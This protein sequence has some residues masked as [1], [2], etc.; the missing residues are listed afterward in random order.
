MEV[1]NFRKE[2]A[3]RR[4]RAS[5][6]TGN[7]ST[8]TGSSYGEKSCFDRRAAGTSFTGSVSH[9]SLLQEQFGPKEEFAK[10]ENTSS[11]RS[12]QGY[13]HT[14]VRKVGRCLERGRFLSCLARGKTNQP[15]SQKDDF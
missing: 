10:Q 6:G 11:K 2:G 7:K 13:R 3:V 1:W 4:R 15:K 14:Q 9:T 12:L 5:F 8:L